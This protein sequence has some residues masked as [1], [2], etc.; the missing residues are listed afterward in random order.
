ML[1]TKQEIETIKAEAKAEAKKILMQMLVEQMQGA[2][3]NTVAPKADD[4]DGWVVAPLNDDEDFRE[5]NLY[6]IS[7][8]VNRTGTKVESFHNDEWHERKIQTKP[9]SNTADYVNLPSAMCPQSKSK[10]GLVTV[11]VGRLVLGAFTEMPSYIQEVLYTKRGP[12]ILF[13]LKLVVHTAGKQNSNL[14][15]LRWVD[16]STFS[17]AVKYKLERMPHLASE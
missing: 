17:K 5:L 6:G 12:T 8:R 3:A 11:T 4:E 9:E 16:E 2:K 14:E 15:N 13:G 1:F 7:I 10:S